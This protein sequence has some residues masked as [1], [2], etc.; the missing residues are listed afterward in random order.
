M[1]EIPAPPLRLSRRA[2]LRLTLQTARCSRYPLVLPE[3]HDAQP[4]AVRVPSARETSDFSRSVTAFS[5][6]QERFHS[7]VQPTLRPF[8]SRLE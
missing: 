7:A 5:I 1:K 3:N 6:R 4:K 2:L 8:E